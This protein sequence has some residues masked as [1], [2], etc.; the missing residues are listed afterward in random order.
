[1]TALVEFDLPGSRQIVRATKVMEGGKI[2]S[3]GGAQVAY[4]PNAA[5][6]RQIR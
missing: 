4:A 2:V 6:P 1:M 5:R 3:L